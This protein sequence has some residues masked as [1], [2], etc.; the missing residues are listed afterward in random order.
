VKRF[1]TRKM[2]IASVSTM[3][4][5]TLVAGIAYAAA[6][7]S[8]IS[9]QGSGSGSATGWT[10]L[11]SVPSNST[12]APGNLAASPLYP[13]GPGVAGVV[14]ITNPNPYAVV[15]TAIDN[16]GGSDVSGSCIAGTVNATNHDGTAAAPLVQHDGTT[17]S[18]A[19][20]G[21]GLYDVT[22]TMQNTADNSCQGKTFTVNMHVSAA[23]ANF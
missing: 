10:A 4:G 19:N 15:V 16:N 7:G 21:T 1:L 8:W 14:S 11:A 20:G 3:A 13:G 22:Y 5:V 17:T 2:V 9:P 12:T 18:I 6:V 23:S